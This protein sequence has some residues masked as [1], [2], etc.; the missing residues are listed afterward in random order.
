M[1]HFVILLDNIM[2]YICANINT[3]ENTFQI[4]QP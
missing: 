3:P 2:D 1:K 4:K